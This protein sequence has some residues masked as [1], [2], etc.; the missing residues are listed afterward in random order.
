MLVNQN[1]YVAVYGKRTRT[2]LGILQNSYNMAFLV[3]WCRHFPDLVEPVKFSATI[4][5]Y[6]Y[7]R[8]LKYKKFEF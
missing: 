8:A 3:S 1:T 4:R 6:F 5:V 7:E 2:C